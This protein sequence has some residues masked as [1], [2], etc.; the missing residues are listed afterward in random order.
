MTGD[1][2]IETGKIEEKIKKIERFSG[3]SFWKNLLLD[4]FYPFLKRALPELYADADTEAEPVSLNI[5]FTDVLKTTDPKKHKN[6]RFADLLI[7]VPLKNGTAK[8]VLLHIE[9]QSSA[10]GGDL[11]ERMY[12]Y[13]CF[14]YAHYRREIAAIAIITGKRPKNE[15]RR[16]SRST[17]GTSVDYD[18]NN[19]VLSE[20]DDEELMG[21]GNPIDIVLY[22]SK[23]AAKTKVELQ[24]YNYLRTAA[25]LLADL[26]WNV[27][28][29]YAFLFFVERII[30]LKD[31][32]L[33]AEYIEY[34]EQLDREGKIVYVTMAEEYYTKKGI[35]K[36]I[37]K[38]RLEG[39]LEGRLEGKLE[40]A[41]NLLARGDSPETISK[42]A[43]LSQ[44]KI[45]E[46]MI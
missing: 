16:Y 26:G 15:S 45:R 36:G 17:Y 6:S 34:L 32:K 19:L 2:K 12:F 41:R 10:G 3:D 7:D 43:D 14:I 21:S 9:A 44:D 8:C 22:A 1:P 42:I 29:K 5:E 23:Y 31:E 46:L 38:G 11:A 24:K 13:Q 4:Y 30:N 27:D 39:K 33:K 37:E 25:G 35:E 40:V 20:L 28:E 18:Y